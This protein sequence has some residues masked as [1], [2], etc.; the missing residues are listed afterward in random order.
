MN[1]LVP[2]F[3]FF[4]GTAIGSFL[5]VVIF[6]L[7]KRRKFLNTKQRSR[8]MHCK[9]ILR[10]V[11]LVPIFSYVFLLGRCR[12]CKKPI[13]PQYIIVEAM[14]GLI[15]V[16]L[17]ERYGLGLPFFIGLLGACSLLTLA[18]I[19]GRHK[20]VP[21]SISLPTIV[22]LF[23]LQLVH[24]FQ[25]QD[26]QFTATFWTDALVLILAML[27]GAGW[28]WLQWA[29]SKGRWVGSGD[30]RIGAILGAFL[31]LPLVAVALFA[32]YMGG[33]VW[34]AILLARGKVKMKSQLPFGVFLGAAGILAYV[35]GPSVV[36]WYQG[37]IGL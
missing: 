19:D 13:S 8:C 9:K 7:P 4:F 35:F 32:S 36:S 11:D 12:F 6:R 23:F 2:V 21:D 26:W 18:F 17:F 3:L 27:I 29:V 25:V 10:P 16:L 37:L 22:L 5:N 34:A 1:T 15:F 30:I 14:T 20:V 33:S 31:G 28:F 24:I